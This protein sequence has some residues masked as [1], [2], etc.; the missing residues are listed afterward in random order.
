MLVR[1]GKD[2]DLLRAHSFEKSQ[3]GISTVVYVLEKVQILSLKIH[4]H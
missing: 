2:C 1:S 4:K 3:I